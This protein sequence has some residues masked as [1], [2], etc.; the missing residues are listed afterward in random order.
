VLDRDSAKGVLLCK[1]SLF[2]ALV[3]QLSSSRMMAAL[4]AVDG[5]RG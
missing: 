1:P 2:R 3:V 5:R 4:V